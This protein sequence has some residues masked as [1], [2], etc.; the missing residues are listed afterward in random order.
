MNK[1]NSTNKIDVVKLLLWLSV[2]LI[3]IFALSAILIIPSINKL[4]VAN[5]VLN[6]SNTKLSQ[7]KGKNENVEKQLNEYL[8][9]NKVNLDKIHNDFNIE[10]FKNHCKT[11]FDEVSLEKSIDFSEEY[12]SYQLQ[13][14]TKITSPSVFYNFIDS[15]ENYPNIL[16]VHFPIVLK[17]DK[18][19]IKAQFNLQVYKR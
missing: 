6:S 7:F 13:V 19:L 2:F 10:K 15:L 8:A 18:D 1:D 14:S 16:R 12:V 17:S 9:E 4:K 11:F 3:V 5:E